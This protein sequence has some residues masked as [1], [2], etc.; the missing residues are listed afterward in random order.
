M[1]FA[2]LSMAAIHS[3][4][5]LQMFLLSVALVKDHISHI[6]TLNCMNFVT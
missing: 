5:L 6:V 1:C 4:E 2:C 3:E